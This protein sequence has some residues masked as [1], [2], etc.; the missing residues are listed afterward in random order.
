[1]KSLFLKISL[2]TCVALFSVA[3]SNRE[4]LSDKEF[5]IEGKISGLEDG[6][7]IHL[8]RWDGNTRISI[9][10]DTIRDGRF[11]FKEETLSNPERMAVGPRGDDFP[12]LPLYVWVAPKARITIKGNGKL[13][14]TWSVKSSIPYQK[15]ENRYTDKNRDVIAESS[16]ISVEENAASSKKRAA[17]SEDEA[18]SY[19]K[20]VDSLKVIDDSLEIIEIYGDISIMEKTDI[21]PIWLDKMNGVS[22][23]LK[24][25]KM[26][27]EDKE[28]LRK[29][30]EE[31]YSRMSEEDKNTP[32]GYLIT[33]KL[34]PPAVVNV[35]DDMA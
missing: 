23:T 21:S 32:V 14:P 6:T 4:K 20:I 10:T 18:L 9:A 16:R 12:S 26:D 29:K 31:L 35:G 34:F 25:S 7:V 22:M 27:V 8:I 17:S 28:N 13:H 11:T 19:K 15:E 3:C 33:A 5:L 30:A 1:M 24:Y 2:W